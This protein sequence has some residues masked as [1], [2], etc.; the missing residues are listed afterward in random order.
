MVVLEGQAQGLV[1][2]MCWWWDAGQTFKQCGLFPF[3]LCAFQRT[4]EEM[5]TGQVGVYRGEAIATVLK[6]GPADFGGP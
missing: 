2:G 3:H 1:S 4:E 5:V 6:V